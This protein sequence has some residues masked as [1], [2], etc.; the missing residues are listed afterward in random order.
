MNE[1]YIFKNDLPHIEKKEELPEVKNFPDFD[2]Y[3]KLLG[4]VFIKKA[5]MC[6]GTKTTLIYKREKPTKMTCQLIVD[7]ESLLEG[8]NLE[9]EHIKE[10]YS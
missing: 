4:F 3:M 2:T 6:Q 10:G 5:S 8:L 9:V 7:N 1:E